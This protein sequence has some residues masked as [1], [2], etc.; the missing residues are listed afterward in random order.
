MPGPPSG[1]YLR[2]G[3]TE[4][5][6]QQSSCGSRSRRPSRVWRRAPAGEFPYLRAGGRQS[7]R[8]RQAHAQMLVLDALREV[9][10]VRQPADFRLQDMRRR[11][12]AMGH[13]PFVV[14]V[15][16]RRFL[17]RA[18][19]RNPKLPALVDAERRALEVAEDSGDL[20]VAELAPLY[21]A[22]R[23]EQLRG[24]TNPKGA[25]ATGREL[26]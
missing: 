13:L 11:S 9:D 5:A 15:Q 10:L 3:G 2:G 17:L 6:W 8:C 23:S 19:E 25:D 21:G 24:S 12:A 22:R 26:N 20:L 4:S 16:Q 1:S 14:P 7:E 18:R